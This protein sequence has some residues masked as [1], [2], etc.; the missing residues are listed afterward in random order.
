MGKGGEGGPGSFSKNAIRRGSGGSDFECGEGGRVVEFS[1]KEESEWI[2]DNRDLSQRSSGQNSMRQET[3]AEKVSCHP[4]YELCTEAERMPG[5]SR[6][7]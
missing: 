1:D 4:I 3:I 2:W 5:T 7:V 6:L